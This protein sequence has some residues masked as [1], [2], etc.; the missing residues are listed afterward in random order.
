MHPMDAFLMML[1]QLKQ[2]QPYAY[3]LRVF[4]CGLDCFCLLVETFILDCADDFAN[5][6][7]T[8]PS[9]RH[10]QTIGPVFDNFPDAIEAINVTFQRSYA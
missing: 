3:T 9:M 7:I 6:F 1:T 4:G 8:Q 2:G 10:Y 5:Y